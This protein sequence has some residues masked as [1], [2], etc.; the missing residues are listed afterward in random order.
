M[1]RQ[2]RIVPH[3]RQLAHLDAITPL[4]L[5]RHRCPHILRELDALV[6]EEFAA[7]YGDPDGRRRREGVVRGRDVGMG[8]WKLLVPV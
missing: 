2:K 4:A 8:H 5:P 7:A 6:T 1:R 3:I